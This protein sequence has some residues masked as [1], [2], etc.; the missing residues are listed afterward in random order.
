[1]EPV[2]APG[3]VLIATE[4]PFGNVALTPEAAEALGARVHMLESLGHLWA[5]QVP[6]EAASVLRDFHA[7]LR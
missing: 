7:S 5:L 3:L 1:M 4:K 2:S 6:A